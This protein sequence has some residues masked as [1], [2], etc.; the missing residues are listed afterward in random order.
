MLHTKARDK[1]LIINGSE[2]I[3][4]SIESAIAE[5]FNGKKT[6]VDYL[7]SELDGI[8]KYHQPT[9]ELPMYRDRTVVKN[10]VKVEEKLLLALKRKQLLLLLRQRTLK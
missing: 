6:F 1:A 4:K 8:S 3:D 7:E 9:D 5:Y 2:S 10:K